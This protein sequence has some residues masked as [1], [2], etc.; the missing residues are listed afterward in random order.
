MKL[1]LTIRQ[2][3]STNLDES[4]F[5]ALNQAGSNLGLDVFMVALSTIGLTYVLVLVGPIL[6]WRKRREL[7]FDVV[8]LIIISDLVVMG[9]K[10]LIM[11]ERPFE[12]LT[13]VHMFAWGPLT[14][15]TSYSMPSAHAT[16]AFAVAGL[17]ALGTRR[18]VGASVLVLA[19]LIGLS[20]IYLGMHWPGDVLVGALLGILLAIIMHW[21]GIRDNSYTRARNNMIAWLH[22]RCCCCSTW[23]HLQPMPPH[24]TPPPHTHTHL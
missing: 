20:R 2:C 24:Q 3:G 22:A 15:T 17:I 11:R 18:R 5:R 8:V 16:R 14:S 4:V 9:L 10:L 19:T 21:V 7:A 1:Q 12:M 6:W 23:Q 13:D